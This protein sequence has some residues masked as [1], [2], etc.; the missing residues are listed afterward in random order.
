[1]SF[2]VSLSGLKGAQADL[3]G[4]Q[5]DRVGHGKQVGPRKIVKRIFFVLKEHPSFTWS[6]VFREFF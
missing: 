1:M 6:K 5:H 4:A 3:S 2:Y